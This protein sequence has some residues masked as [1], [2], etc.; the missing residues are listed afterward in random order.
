[1]T[2]SLQAGCERGGSSRL[3]VVW[4]GMAIW[5]EY[6]SSEIFRLY[7]QGHANRNNKSITNHCHWCIFHQDHPKVVHTMIDVRDQDR[8]E[9]YLGVSDTPNHQ[10]EGSDSSYVC[11]D[12][13]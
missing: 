12:L 7:Q 10:E 1:M 8:D 4:R 5:R 6:P 3:G 13:T 11:H 2:H 9:Y